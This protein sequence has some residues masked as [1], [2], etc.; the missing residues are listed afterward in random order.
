MFPCISDIK[1]KSSAKG[2]FFFSAGM[3]LKTFDSCTSLNM[4][5]ESR[6]SFLIWPHLCFFKGNFTSMRILKCMEQSLII[7]QMFPIDISI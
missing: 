4:D 5:I 7:D 6:L 1:R 2:T 3:A